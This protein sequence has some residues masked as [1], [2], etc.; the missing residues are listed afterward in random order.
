MARSEDK[1]QLVVLLGTPDADGAAICSETVSAGDPTFPGPPAGVPL[2]PA[3]FH[4]VERSIKAQIPSEGYETDLAAIED[5]VVIDTIC[6][7]LAAVRASAP[8]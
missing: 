5:L 3:V 7:H 2:G 1:D 4:V 6:S 8:R